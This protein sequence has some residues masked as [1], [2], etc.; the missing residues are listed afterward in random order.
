MVEGDL[1]YRAVSEPM[2]AHKSGIRSR[3]GHCGR[4]AKARGSQGSHDAL[5][6]E[7]ELRQTESPTKTRPGME[8][9]L[10]NWLGLVTAMRK[11]DGRQDLY[12]GLNEVVKA[13]KRAIREGREL[14]GNGEVVEE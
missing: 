5:D 4:I 9:A 12:S 6:T 13:A 2:F 14:N 7:S 8:A 10:E 11:V 3:A 1:T